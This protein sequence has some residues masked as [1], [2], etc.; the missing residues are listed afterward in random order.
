MTR[1]AWLLVGFGLGLLVAW[2]FGERAR[3][4][5][6]AYQVHLAQEAAHGERL[7]E[8]AAELRRNR[9]QIQEDMPRLQ[10]LAS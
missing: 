10:R 7:R 1:R 5:V 8:K 4:Q 2:S 9:R 6:A 3:R